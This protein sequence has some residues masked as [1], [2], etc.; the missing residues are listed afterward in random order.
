MT[1]NQWFAGKC[2]SSFHAKL[3]LEEIWNAL[4]GAGRPPVQAGRMLSDLLEA[5]MEDA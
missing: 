4:I 5:M 2:V 1:F 3:A